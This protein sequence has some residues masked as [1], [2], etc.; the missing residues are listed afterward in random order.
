MKPRATIGERID[1]AKDSEGWLASD[2]MTFVLG[3]IAPVTRDTRFTPV[4]FY[5][6]QT[7][8]FHFE[9]GFDQISN[10]C[11][12]MIPILYGTDWV[13]VEI[14]RSDEGIQVHTVQCPPTMT[15]RLAL[16]ACHI[17]HAPAHRLQLSHTSGDSI[18]QMCGWTLLRRWIQRVQAQLQFR[19]IEHDH[20]TLSL[21]RRRIVDRIMQISA[22]FWAV[23]EAPS[24]LQQVAWTLRKAFFINMLLMQTSVHHVLDSH[25]IVAVGHPLSCFD[26]AQGPSG[27]ECKF[28]SNG[29]LG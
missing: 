8:E 24:V 21:D 25:A 22:D 3:R 14:S 26:H 23:T 10:E 27:T 11:D 6:P 12:T 13:A 29:P 20:H 15:E 9:S 17:L 4:A 2:A 18:P 1:F 16:F 28:G 7:D 5:T 19:N